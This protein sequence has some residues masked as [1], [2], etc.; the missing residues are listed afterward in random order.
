MTLWLIPVDSLTTV[1]DWGLVSDVSNT[2]VF[3]DKQRCL[4]SLPTP[5][6]TERRTY[7]RVGVS[8]LGTP[9]ERPRIENLLLRSVRDPV[10][11]CVTEV[12]FLGQDRPN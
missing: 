1:T 12:L 3:S 4:L 11:L 8:S 10:F 9:G 7:G 6:V 5:P 2:E